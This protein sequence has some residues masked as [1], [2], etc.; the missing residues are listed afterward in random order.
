MMKQEIIFGPP[1][2]GKTTHLLNILE[3][4]LKTCDPDNIAFV[5]FTKK[6]AYEARDRAIK[7]FNYHIEDLPYFRTLHSLAFLQIGARPANMVR[8]KDYKYLSNLLGISINSY[9]IEDPF[10]HDRYLFLDYYS[11]NSMLPLE[12]VWH[13]LGENEEWLR[14]K[15]V[16]RCVDN[17]KKEKG[18]FDFTDL[19]ELSIKH[20]KTVPVEIAIIDEAQ[21][22]TTLQWAM[23]KTSFKNCK[24]IYIAGDDDQSIYKWAGA[25]VNHFLNLKGEYTYLGQSYR[26]PRKVHQFVHNKIL[27][28]IKNRVKKVFKPRD[29]EGGIFFHS[30]LD[31]IT[32]DSSSWLILARNRYFLKE[33]EEYTRIQGRVYK[34]K[35]KKSVEEKH[36]AAIYDWED[37]RKGKFVK[38]MALINHFTKSR[39][40]R[41]KPW[42][43]A[44]IN[45][46]AHT[47][48]Y[49]QSIL[50]RGGN[51]RKD[52]NIIIDTIH[53]VKG[54]QA[55][56]VILILDM[57]WKTYQNFQ[58]F[59]DDENRVFY[60]GATRTKENLH[61]VYPN[62]DIGYSF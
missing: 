32:L 44:F 10:S 17:Y 48:E 11:R 60:V 41:S 50:R 56:N 15:H 37:H 49:Y 27:S 5:S 46:P 34:T 61:I 18:Y 23:V 21:D 3:K 20:D 33:A 45:M 59:P 38:D 43:E 4:E 55:D 24:K 9:N 13:Q 6:G 62:S 8:F 29:H 2:T 52:P 26:I 19:I 54:G 25:D 31:E 51:L 58:K 28:Q 22:L 53:S 57:S 12:E 14:L 16:I 47:R 30:Y 1:G 7:K 39:P 42:F 35:E 36:W 40:D